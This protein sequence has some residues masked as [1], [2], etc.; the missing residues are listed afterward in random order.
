MIP[1]SIPED[2]RELWRV[3]AECIDVLNA[4]QNMTV[5]VEGLEERMTGKLEI[6]GGACILK[7][8]AVNN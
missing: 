7:I 2:C 1:T 3:V 8:N 6:S 5:K 4:L